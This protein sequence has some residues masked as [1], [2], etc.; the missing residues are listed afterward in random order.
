MSKQSN[1][2]FTSSLKVCETKAARVTEHRF[3]PTTCDPGLKNCR[4]IFSRSTEHM[5]M[6]DVVDVDLPVIAFSAVYYSGHFGSQR[7]H[8]RSG[9]SVYVDQSE[10]EDLGLN[11]AVKVGTEKTRGKFQS[12]TQIVEPG[13]SGCRSLKMKLDY[14]FMAADFNST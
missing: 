11:G 2:R 9:Q 8:A 13:R 6:T 10:A 5:L 14:S 3:C 12:M 1:V 7:P 4:R